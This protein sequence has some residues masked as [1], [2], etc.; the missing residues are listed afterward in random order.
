LVDLI[1]RRRRPTCQRKPPPDCSAALALE[2]FVLLGPSQH[3]AGL[4]STPITCQHSSS[5]GDGGAHSTH[6]RWLFNSALPAPENVV[7]EGSIRA[8]MLEA[9]WEAFGGQVHVLEIELAE[10][11]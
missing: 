3:S 8:E 2:V 9:L 5:A 1:P 6:V 7:V 10:Y 4:I 11:V